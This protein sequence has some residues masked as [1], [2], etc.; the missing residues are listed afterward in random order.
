MPFAGTNHTPVMEKVVYG[1]NSTLS[2]SLNR[3]DVGQAAVTAVFAMTYLNDEDIPNDDKAI[4]SGLK[5]D[6]RQDDRVV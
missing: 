3:G 5:T 2:A 1:P 6:G 4:V